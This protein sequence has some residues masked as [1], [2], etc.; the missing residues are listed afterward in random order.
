LTKI[1][2]CDIVFIEREVNKMNIIRTL[3]FGTL[4][5]VDRSKICPPYDKC[6]GYIDSNFEGEGFDVYELA[7]GGCVAVLEA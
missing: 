5:I 7:E 1:Q 4:E 2:R 6:I 3:D